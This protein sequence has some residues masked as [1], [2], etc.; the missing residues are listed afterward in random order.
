MSRDQ[1]YPSHATAVILPTLTYDTTRID[2]TRLD[3]VLFAGSPTSCLVWN[4]E[5]YNT[6]GAPARGLAV[7]L[8]AIQGLDHAVSLL[9]EQPK[10][11]DK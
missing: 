3:I 1:N 2:S 6:S 9:F 11:K 10:G 5:S 4:W 7:V 8:G